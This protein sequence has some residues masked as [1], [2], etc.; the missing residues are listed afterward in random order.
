MLDHFAHGKKYVF[1][2]IQVSHTICGDYIPYKFQTAI[3]TT[4]IWSKS[5]LKIAVFPHHFQFSS[6][7]LIE[8]MNVRPPISKS[9]YYYFHIGFKLASAKVVEKI[10]YSETS[11]HRK[12]GLV[13]KEKP[14]A[15]SSRVFVQNIVIE[16]RILLNLTYK[17]QFIAQLKMI[18]CHWVKKVVCL[19]LVDFI[20]SFFTYFIWQHFTFN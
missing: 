15:H 19:Y 17:F 9:C 8:T 6:P 16:T 2:T 12:G 1:S 13:A 3:T 10:W 18:L 14:F 5:S 7:R 11:L 20:L 4:S